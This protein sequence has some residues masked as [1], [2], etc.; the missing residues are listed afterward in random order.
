M[1][2]WFLSLVCPWFS[3]PL[4]S[5]VERLALAGKLA[6][7]LSCAATVSAE[8]TRSILLARNLPGK[9]LGMVV[10]LMECRGEYELQE[11]LP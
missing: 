6:N 7:I 9:A 2:S 10:N 1:P 11:V 3:L 5:V 8:L 4:S